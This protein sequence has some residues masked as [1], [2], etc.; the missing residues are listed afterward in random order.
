MVDVGPNAV[1]ELELFDNTIEQFSIAVHPVNEM[2]QIK[3]GKNHMIEIKIFFNHIIFI[4]I[5]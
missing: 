3:S 4:A 1:S 5:F 2:Y